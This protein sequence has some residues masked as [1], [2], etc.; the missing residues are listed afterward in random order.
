MKTRKLISIIATVFVLLS[1]IFCTAGAAEMSPA[2]LTDSSNTELSWTETSTDGYTLVYTI[3]QSTLPTKAQSRATSQTV[4]GSG[5]VT[6]KDGS[7]TLYTLS[8]HATFSVNVGISA[9]C[10]GCSYTYS[11]KESSW[12]FDSATATKSGNTA[13]ATGTFYKK[14]LFVTTKTLTSS[15]KLICDKNGNITKQ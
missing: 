7:T 2:E 10:T 6:V 3:T 13:T 12:H 15:V 1:S 5:T 11:I 9:T 14:V 8:V 4:Q